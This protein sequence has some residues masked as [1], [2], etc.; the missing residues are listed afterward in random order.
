MET[1]ASIWRENIQEY[2]SSDI[3]CSKMRTVSESEAQGN[4]WASKDK[5]TSTFSCKIEALE[6]LSFK[7]FAARVG[8]FLLSVLQYDFMNKR[9]IPIFCYIF[10]N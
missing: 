5:Y 1:I 4:L 9:I 3:I 8:C 7:H 10:L 6:L 2:L